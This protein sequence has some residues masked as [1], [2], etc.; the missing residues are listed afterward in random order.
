VFNVIINEEI[1]K[2][3]RVGAVMG[4]I[5]KLKNFGKMMGGKIKNWPRWIKILCLVVVIGSGLVVWRTASGQDAPLP[6]NVGKIEKQDL[7]R[8]VFTN[9]SLEAENQQTFFSPVES[10]LMELNVELGDRVKK[11]QVLGR[12]DTLELGRLHQQA[13]ANL[14]S[15]KADLAKAQASD[16]KQQCNEAEAAY[17]KAK[18]HLDRI[19]ALVEAGA[20]GLEE[21]ETAEA[22]MQKCLTSYQEALV[23]KEQKASEKQIEALQNEVDLAGQEVAQAQ[24]RLGLATFTAAFDGVVTSVGAKE[25]NRVQEGTEILVLADDQSLKVTARVNE[26]DAGE[27][28]EG[29]N[30]AITCLALPGKKFEGIIS[31]IGGAAVQDKGQNGTTALKIPATVKL[32]GDY[33]RLKLGYS[34]SLS[35]KTK[36]MK[37]VLT[38]PVEAVVEDKGQKKVWLFKDGRL[39]ERKI[40]TDRGNELKDVV[41]SGLQ[42]GDAVV[43]NPSPDLTAGKKAIEAPEEI[44]S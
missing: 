39:D 7:E 36:E 43:K 42:E 44:K 13:L 37:D 23:K 27:L 34:V 18:N 41:Q 8:V 10:T 29:Q 12:L 30:V 24:E 19:K 15:K 2:C 11:G 4:F 16:D 17:L 35:I 33:S 1:F 6:V 25:G 5:H 21:L 14:A 9:G 40:E 22:D 31:H 32:K 28:Q 3:V 20:A 38:I 26:V